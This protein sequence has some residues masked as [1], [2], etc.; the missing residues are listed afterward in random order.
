MEGYMRMVYGCAV[1]A[2][3]YVQRPAQN[4][5]RLALS[6]HHYPHS[7][8]QRLTEPGASLPRLAGR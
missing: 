4:I 1:Y 8:I 5:W 7:L 3:V 2:H 6:L